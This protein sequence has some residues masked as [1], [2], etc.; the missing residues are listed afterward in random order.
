MAGD[1]VAS[2]L[3]S[4]SEDDIVRMLAR[5]EKIAPEAARDK[6]VEH[7]GA[8]DDLNALN[9]DQ[10]IILASH[11]F[12]PEVTSA[13]LWLNQKAPGENLITCVKLTPHRDA[14]NN[15]LYVQASTIIPVPGVEEFVITVGDSV[16]PRPAVPGSSLGEKLTAT[17]ARNK[18]DEV[19]RFFYTVRDMVLSDLPASVRPDRRSRWG[20]SSW[21]YRYFHFWYRRPPWGNWDLSY[22]INLYPQDGTGKWSAEVEFGQFAVEMEEKLLSLPVPDIQR[23]ETGYLKVALGAD[24]LEHD[25][26][27]TIAQAT[28]RLIE[29]SRL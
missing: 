24:V 15:T 6:L 7:L 4:A 12:A 11:R 25:F 10:R 2:Y 13:V 20:G 26:A 28:R 21:E 22:R 3:K 14:S 8:D 23:S 27:T 17:F 19:T 1:Q 18:N 5:H 16:E 9:N 29:T